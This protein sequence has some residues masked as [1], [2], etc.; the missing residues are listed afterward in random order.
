[1]N[2]ISRTLR[3]WKNFIWQ[4]PEP[5][6]RTIIAILAG[7]FVLYYLLL[8]FFRIEIP[9]NWF[10]F[11]TAQAVSYPWTFF[12]YPLFYLQPIGMLLGGLV[13]WWIGGSIER[14]WGRIAFLR[15][16]AIL[17]LLPSVSLFIGSVLLKSIGFSF[18]ANFDVGLFSLWTPIAGLTVAWAL[19]NPDQVIHLYFVISVKARYVKWLAI[20]LQYYYL[21]AIWGAPWLAFFALTGVAY[22]YQ[23]TR[24][25]TVFSYSNS[26][27]AY[28]A[29]ASNP[30]DKSIDSLAY[31]W[32]KIKRFMTLR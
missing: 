27:R 11:H 15:L 32:R 19:I 13:F 30:L 3:R 28:P 22:A 7:S 4:S 1:M 16:F 24:Q 14:S 2:E 18:F 5:I 26:D 9:N 29:G 23:Y 31:V 8:W 12:L 20:F 21:A 25:R 10:S 6:T 17:I